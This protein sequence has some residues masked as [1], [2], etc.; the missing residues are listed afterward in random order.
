MYL[1]RGEKTFA[2]LNY[3]FLTIVTLC[4]LIPFL[5]VLSTSLISV[6]EWARRGAFVLIPEKIDLSAYQLL[7]GSK[8]MVFNA[9]RVTLFRFSS[10]RS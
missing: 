10:G 7:L 2:V 9:Y 5:T 6:Q 4:F 3:I 8:S 1:S